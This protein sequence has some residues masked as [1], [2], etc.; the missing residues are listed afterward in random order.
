M[1]HME[2]ISFTYLWYFLLFSP[3]PVFVKVIAIKTIVVRKN[4]YS[5]KK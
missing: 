5:S 2:D 3:I 1:K 4:K